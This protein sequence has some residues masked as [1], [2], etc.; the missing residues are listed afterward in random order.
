MKK[1]KI[2]PSL[3]S[4]NFCR[5]E[6][7]IESVSI[8]GADLLH[9]DIMDGH[10]VPNLTFGTPIV[11][12]ISQITKLPL[13]THLMVINPSDYIEQ[14]AMMGVKYFSFH[15]E[16]V[17]HSHRMIEQIKQHQMKTGIALN[18]GT[19]VS[20]IFDLLPLLDF[21]L[22]MSVNPGF[23]GQNFIPLVLD[24]IRDLV[25]IRN[26]KNLNFMIEID[27][28]VNAETIK[29]I[30]E[31]GTDIVVAGSYIFGSNDYAEAIKSL[32]V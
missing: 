20:A 30:T 12:A 26:A 19:P 23:S 1:I 4:A 3:L 27:G 10:F 18:P 6:N 21:V 13:D 5:L 8:A 29:N 14:F 22:V 17:D 31:A 11:K 25:T 9:L 15:I 7:E 2:A 16:T 28:G 24:K 32:K